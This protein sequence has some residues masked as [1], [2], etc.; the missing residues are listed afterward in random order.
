MSRT[1]GHA[2]ITRII[3]L[4]DEPFLTSFYAF[5]IIFSEQFLILTTN[6]NTDDIWIGWGL[7]GL[8][9]FLYEQKAH[10]PE[11][12][13]WQWHC[14]YQKKP[15]SDP[16]FELSQLGQDTFSLP[17]APPTLPQKKKFSRNA[18]LTK[19]H[20]LLFPFLAQVP[21]PIFSSSH[22]WISGT[23]SSLFAAMESNN[24]NQ[25]KSPI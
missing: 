11:R 21:L 6:R 17:L 16:G 4:I 22:R 19:Q 3:F 8:H 20:F 25:T 13:D 5:L 2:R 1:K 10:P 24:W 15:K 7:N 12:I 18:F 23:N 14:L 9:T